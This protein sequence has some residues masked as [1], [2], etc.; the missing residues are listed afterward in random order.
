MLTGS[1]IK[2]ML[3]VQKITNGVLDPLS[4]TS[5]ETYVTKELQPVKADD[6][7]HENF[8]AGELPE[9]TYRLSLLYNG[10]IFEQVV[11]IVP[12]KLTFV[13]FILK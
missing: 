4:I 5:I 7:W 3:N 13:R 1:Q 2:G 6:A 9:G 8:A 11:K 10:A 12:G